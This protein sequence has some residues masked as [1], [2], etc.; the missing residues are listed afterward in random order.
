MSATGLDSKGLNG[1]RVPLIIDGV[2][3]VTAIIGG[4]TMWN[5]LE[6]LERQYASSVSAEKIAE[7]NGKIALLDDQLKRQVN[8]LKNVDDNSRRDRESMHSRIDRLER[9]AR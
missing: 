5:K 2:M 8:D 1:M 7:L 9:G 4:T 3:I 6:F